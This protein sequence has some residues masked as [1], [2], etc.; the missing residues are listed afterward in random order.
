MLRLSVFRE[1]KT[2]LPLKRIN[3]I[4]DLAVEEESGP[5]S[6]GVVNLVFTGDRL[7]RKLN[8]EHRK[9]DKATDVLS[10]SVDPPTSPQAVFGEI[11]ISCSTARR[12]AKEMGMELVDEYLRLFCH[13]LLHLFGYDHIR[14]EDARVMRQKEDRLLSRV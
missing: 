11:Y 12:Q 3:A 10:F 6:S 5:G 14:R 1:A 2:R 13:G 4:F 9:K 7:I 8:R